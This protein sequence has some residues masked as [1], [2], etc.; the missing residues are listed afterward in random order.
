MWAVSGRRNGSAHREERPAPKMIQRR[1]GM[2]SVGLPDDSIRPM[3]ACRNQAKAVKLYLTQR[4]LQVSD[5]IGGI[6]DTYGE[7]DQRGV[8]LDSRAGEAGVGHSA[9]MLN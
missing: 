4:L 1:S 9:R 6:L 2:G 7:A 3:P 5:K 8:D